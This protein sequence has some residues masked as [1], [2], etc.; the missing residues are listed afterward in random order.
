MAVTPAISGVITLFGETDAIALTVLAM[1]IAGFATGF[2][3]LA[4]VQKKYT[5]V[6]F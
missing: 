2:V 4:R 6:L 1:L 3:L 5:G